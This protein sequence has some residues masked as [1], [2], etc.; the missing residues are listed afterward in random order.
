M[1][2][3][4]YELYWQGPFEID[5]KKPDSFT[6]PSASGVY[7]WVAGKRG[8]RAVSYVGQTEN[9]TERFY[10]H[11]ASQLGGEYYL[12]DTKTIEDGLKLTN[13]YTPGSESFFTNFLPEWQR[14]TSLAMGNLTAYEFYWAEVKG[15]KLLR[16]RI[17][18]AL[19]HHAGQSNV[20]LQNTRTTHAPHRCPAFRLDSIL[21]AG[22]DSLIGISSSFKY[23]YPENKL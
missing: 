19:I 12:Y 15:D 22:V 3:P 1:P 20:Y 5:P 14:Y 23:G 16:E 10:Q 11:F 4:H 6:P 13:V 17:E 7:L 21:P 2:I 18:S 8:N 9:L